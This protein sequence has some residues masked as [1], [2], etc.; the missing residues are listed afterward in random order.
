MPSPTILAAAWN[1]FLDKEIR[2]LDTLT[3]DER[4]ELLEFLDALNGKLPD[5]IGPPP[6]LTPPTQNASPT[7]R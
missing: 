4:D 6:D 5:D 1:P 3:F 7:G 2:S